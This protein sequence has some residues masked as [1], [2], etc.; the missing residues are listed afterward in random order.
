MTDQIVT[1]WIT[2][3]ARVKDGDREGVSAFADSIL[4]NEDLFQAIT[5]VL[6]ENERFKSVDS[7]LII[8]IQLPWT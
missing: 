3:W 1:E 4:A 8:F 7:R 5:H 2:E 6:E